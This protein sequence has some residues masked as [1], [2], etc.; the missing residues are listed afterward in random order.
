M[1][2]HCFILR[3]AMRNPTLSDYSCPVVHPQKYQ[4]PQVELL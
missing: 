2:T 4:T 1:A 3:S